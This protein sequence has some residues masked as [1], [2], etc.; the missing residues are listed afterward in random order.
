MNC[1]VWPTHLNE[2]SLPQSTGSDADRRKFCEHFDAYVLE[3]FKS[4]TFMRGFSPR[5]VEKALTEANKKDLL[6]SFM[7]TWVFEK[8]QCGNCADIATF[9]DRI[10][11][12]KAVWRAWLLELSQNTRFSDAMLVPFLNFAREDH[13]NE[14]GLSLSKR[15]MGFTLLLIDT[16][17]GELIWTSQRQSVLSQ[18]QIPKS[19]S[20][21]PEFPKWDLVQQELM[22]ET[23]WREY[24][25]RVFL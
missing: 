4:Q 20:D 22:I 19:S 2:L 25:G 16:S 24:P 7:N 6:G 5:A 3:S 21:F 14:R 9:Y 10:V 18:S 15:S 8:E 1:R 12:P 13:D 23:L 11:K 17:T